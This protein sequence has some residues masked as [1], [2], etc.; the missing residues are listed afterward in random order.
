MFKDFT[1]VGA[2]PHMDAV[3]RWVKDGVAPIETD[4]ARAAVEDLSDNE[5]RARLHFRIATHA[6]RAGD[7]ATAGRH[8]DAAVQLAPDDFTIWRASLPLND[9]DPFGEEFFTIYQQW[10]EAGSPYH[11]LAGMK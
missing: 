1:G 9:G 11:G 7:K 6:R 10:Q 2:G 4:E 8:F 3:R 5:V